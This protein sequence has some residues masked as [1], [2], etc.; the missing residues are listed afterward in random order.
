MLHFSPTLSHPKISRVSAFWTVKTVTVTAGPNGAVGE[1]RR[2]D[3]PFRQH[4]SVLVLGSTHAFRAEH[5]GSF[6]IRGIG[7]RVVNSGPEATTFAEVPDHTP[8][9]FPVLG[10]SFLGH[11]FS[12]TAAVRKNNPPQNGF[13]ALFRRS[14]RRHEPW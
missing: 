13:R 9:D 4:Q 1:K 6:Q 5:F 7:A 2:S 14:S 8:A 12:I 10:R 3:S 11:P